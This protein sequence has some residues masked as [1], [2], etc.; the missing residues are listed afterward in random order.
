[1]KEQWRVDENREALVA[2]LD[3]LPT[4]TADGFVR[5]AHDHDWLTPFVKNEIGR[6]KPVETGLFWTGGDLVA[7]ARFFLF[8]DG[9]DIARFHVVQCMVSDGRWGVVCLPKVGP[10]NVNAVL[11]R[12]YNT[13]KDDNMV[14]AF[15]K[16]A[17][18]VF[19]AEQ[20]KAK[21]QKG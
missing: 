17:G 6:L 21:R 11:D 10:E 8:D 14:E 7:S 12:V 2:V 18:D 13:L 1:M 5:L 20:R 19:K 3:L 4:R 16:L 9:L 15:I